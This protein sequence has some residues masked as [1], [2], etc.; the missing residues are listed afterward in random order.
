MRIDFNLNRC[1]P[2]GEMRMQFM[3]EPNQKL[4]AGMAARHEAV[5]SQGCISC[6][7]WPDMQVMNCRHTRLL[8]KKAADLIGLNLYRHCVKGHADRATQQDHVPTRIT[9]AIARLTSGS[10]R[11]Q[12]VSRM[13]PPAATTPPDTSAS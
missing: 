11:V 3:R 8:Q 10:S 9:T 13:T 7:H 1:V 2:D 6:A 12:P 4:V 5:T